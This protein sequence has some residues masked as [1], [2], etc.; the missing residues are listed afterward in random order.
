VL[1]AWRFFGVGFAGGW[2]VAYARLAM[3]A[4]AVVGWLTYAAIERPLT[5]TLRY[6]VRFEPAASRAL[7]SR[8]G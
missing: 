6:L 2:L 3:T 8:G 5:K 4:C 7:I 1:I